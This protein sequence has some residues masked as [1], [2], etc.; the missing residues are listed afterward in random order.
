M[1]KK[2]NKP[3]IKIK[4]NKTKKPGKRARFAKQMGFDQTQTQ[5]GY[6]E[7]YSSSGNNSPYGDRRR[8]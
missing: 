6:N 4:T 7:N 2:K 3:H 5:G 8:E 1:K